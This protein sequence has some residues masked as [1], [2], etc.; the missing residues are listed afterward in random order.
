MVAMERPSR[1]GRPGA[2]TPMR[3]SGANCPKILCAVSRAR[4]SQDLLPSSEVGIDSCA[5]ILPFALKATH[6]MLV[7]PTSRPM[8]VAGVRIG[9]NAK[10]Q[11]REGARSLTEE[12]EGNEGDSS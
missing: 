8:N 4:L 3:G 7:P 9:F 2:A 12:N 1:E 11:R 10:T 5:R 6:L